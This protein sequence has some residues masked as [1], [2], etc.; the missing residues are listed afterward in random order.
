MK[1]NSKG[2]PTPGWDYRQDFVAEDIR[3]TQS[4]DGKTLYAIVLNWPEDGKVVVKSLKEG[5][6][7]RSE[8]IKSVTMLGAK[9]PVKWSRTAAGLEITLP[10]DK[11]CDFAYSF[12][13]K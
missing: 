6:G 3:F 11:P 10:K 4:K 12:K 13:I 2:V 5:S 9:E 8:K 7:Y 1:K